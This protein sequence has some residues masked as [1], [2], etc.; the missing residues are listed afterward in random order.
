MASTTDARSTSQQPRSTLFMNLLLMP[1]LTEN[2][3]AEHIPTLMA[4]IR[5]TISI[6][7][8]LQFGSLKVAH[9]GRSCPQ[10]THPQQ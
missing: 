3:Q 5:I 9:Q 4:R 1:N 10:R 7:Q 2:K 6:M 8:L